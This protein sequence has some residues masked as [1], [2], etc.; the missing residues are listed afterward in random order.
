MHT[1]VTN[2]NPGGRAFYAYGG[3]VIY[4]GSVVGHAN[5]SQASHASY[6]SFVYA[7]YGEWTGSYND[8]IYTGQNATGN[9][10]DA[11]YPTGSSGTVVDVEGGFTN[12]N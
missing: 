12:S 2:N 3:S 11:T 6:D 1:V 7:R 5:G 4:A 10:R 9:V 8:V